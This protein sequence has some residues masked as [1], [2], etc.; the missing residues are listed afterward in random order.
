MVR[1]PGGASLS[2][3]VQVEPFWPSK[4]EITVREYATC[5][6][7]KKCAAP[8][9][10]WKTCNW[11][12]RQAHGDH[13]VNCITWRQAKAYCTWAGLRLPSEQE[14]EFAARGGDGRTYPWGEGSPIGRVCVKGDDSG[15]CPVGSAAGDISPFGLLDMAGNVKDWT[16][17]TAKLPGGVEAKVLRGGD[18]QYDRLS[19]VIP[20][21]ATEREFLPPTE[22]AADLGVRCAA[23]V[24]PRR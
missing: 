12:N 23:S 13:P 9:T 18:W 8:K 1:I 6:A 17:S 2:G 19:P 14:W 11:T 20:A 10:D 4:T 5:V 16:A 7:A 3:G 24:Q 21:R 22:F 15:T